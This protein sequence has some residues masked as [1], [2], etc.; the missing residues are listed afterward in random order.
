MG[1]Q[2]LLCGFK[3]ASLGLLL[4]ARTSLGDLGLGQLG[5][6]ERGVHSEKNNQKKLIYLVLFDQ[7]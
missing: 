1:L 3:Q 4:P 6:G 7:L 5:G 2:R